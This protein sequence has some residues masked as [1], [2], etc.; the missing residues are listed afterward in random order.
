M[1][2][3]REI[4]SRLNGLSP[5][6]LPAGGRAAIVGTAI[7]GGAAGTPFGREDGADLIVAEI[8]PELLRAIAT[9]FENLD[10]DDHFRARTIVGENHLL[11]DVDDRRRGADG[12]RV[13]GLVRQGDD[14]GGAGL[15]HAAD[16]RDD[17]I[18]LGRVRVREIERPHHLLFVLLPHLRRVRHDEDRARVDDLEPAL[19][20][21]HHEVERLLER[22]V[23]DVQRDR[24]ATTRA[25]CRSA[26]R[27]C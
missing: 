15:R 10:V 13:R 12:Q 8:E 21:R 7:A 24:P 26:R 3:P 4:V 20:H 17:L 16:L 6:V 22:E 23:A 1:L 9:D 18:H 14:L 25:A 11:D 5:P 2:M 19:A 27:R